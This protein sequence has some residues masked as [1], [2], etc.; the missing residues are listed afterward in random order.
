MVSS[1][2][3]NKFGKT[4]LWTV[5]AVG[6]AVVGVSIRELLADPI[7]WQWFTLAALTLI[8]GSATIRLPSSQASISTSETFV[9]TASLLYGPAAGTVIVAL[10]ALVVS[11]WLSKRLSEPHRI[12][13]N[14]AAPSIS[15]WCSSH[16]FFYVAG[17]AP[18][19]RGP[20]TPTGGFILPALVLFALTYF[21]IN[22]WLITFIISL[23][24][25]LSP[26]TVWKRNFVWLSLNYLG[27]ASVA[28]LLVGYNRT[29]D[30]GYLG[31]I[32]P[33]L[34]V[35]Y[36]TF[37]TTIGRVG[38]AEQHVA[39]LNRL[40]LS[41]IET[42]AM[43]IDA[44]DQ[45]THGHIRRVQVHATALARDVGVNDEKL[46]R[47]IEAA[48]LLH[49]MGKLAVPEYILNKPG[50][51]SEVEFE[52]MKLH[53]SVGADILS[54]IEFP[55]PVVPIVRH[56][57]ENWDGSGYPAGIRGT[58]IPIGARILSVVDCFDALTS[59]RPYRPRLSDQEAI[60]VLLERRGTMYD[61]LVVDAFL[62]SR[63]AQTVL[64]PQRGG[65][66]SDVLNTIARSRQSH[67]KMQVAIA[68]DD[69]T[70]SADE[71][72]AIYD[73][74]R[75]LAGQV[76][77]ADAG[78]V[79][80]KH[81][82]RLIPSSLCVFYFYDSATDELLAGHAVGDNASLVRGLRIALGQRLSGWVAV[83]RQ[84]ISNSDPVLDIGDA[85]KSPGMTLRSTL[86]T[87][88][89]ADQKLVGVLSLYASEPDAFSD[90][91]RRI[92]EALVREIAR[93]F[94]RTS[95]FDD[96]DRRDVVTGLP[97][98]RRLE[99]LLNSTGV[100]GVVSSTPSTVLWIDIVGLKQIN[101]AHG[102]DVGDD[103]LR[104]VAKQAA[105]G[106]RIADILFRYGSDEFIA[107]LSETS[108]E[109]GR[110]VAEMIEHN[111][112]LNPQRLPNGSP[113]DARVS[114]AVVSSPEDGR[115]LED[116]L[117][118][119]RVRAGQPSHDHAR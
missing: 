58:D 11:F 41:T 99:Q 26:I 8:T 7:G 24:R 80:A 113:L 81:L 15:L 90:A 78:D 100:E 72:L 22:S 29:I 66:P 119:A 84:T 39:Q 51:L 20:A 92:I 67:V 118:A 54:A 6:S 74:A 42:L 45:V 68:S 63:N 79:I 18:V 64:V 27:C 112:A 17:L 48:A 49:D 85:A 53:A 31:V 14:L 21:L 96:S 5:I 12:L 33:L 16:V 25:H 94:K 19:A 106:L 36:L 102:R 86:S 2:G 35:L 88:L 104:H 61:P 108:A 28:F 109:V 69:I 57:H 95:E 89:I 110:T 55:Y 75:A 103:V 116:L 114:V 62:R 76:S 105:A 73:I 4:Y 101:T 34:L 47:A 10:D 44:K 3:L 107:L 32:L 93:V 60:E 37:K 56:H 87:P 65:P 40:Y 46:I 115:S 70:T 50:R 117:T 83:N 77:L 82:K 59:D 38:D 91:H 30:L 71:M 23:E 9:F 13:F 98:I 43:A 52:K 111:V 1:P 97:S